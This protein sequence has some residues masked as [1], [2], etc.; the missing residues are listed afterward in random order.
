MYTLISYKLKRNEY[1]MA[2]HNKN[3]PCGRMQYK[4]HK[5][6]IIH[7]DLTDIKS[8]CNDYSNNRTLEQHTQQNLN[9]LIP[10]TTIGRANKWK[11]ILVIKEVNDNG[12]ICLKGALE[13]IITHEIALMSSLNKISASE[14][15]SRLCKSHDNDWKICNSKMIAP[16]L[17]WDELKN[18]LLY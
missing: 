3:I 13:N 5:N 17:F 10:N 14:Y 8:L 7:M 18:R 1:Q 6:D 12:G 2:V 4:I 9:R 16:L 11:L 15:T